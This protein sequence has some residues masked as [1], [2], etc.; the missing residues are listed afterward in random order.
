M[1]K[2]LIVFFSLTGTTARVA[3]AIAGGLR[4]GGQ[5]VDLC[6]IKDSQP[7]DPAGY[8]PLGIGVPAYYYRPPFNVTEYL[9]ALPELHGIRAFVFVLHGTHQGDTGNHVR[10]ALARKGAQ[11]IGYFTSFGKDLYLGYLKKGY[12]F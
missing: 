8:D 9:N 2:S 4:S 10:E 6:N 11:E 12:L 5:R 7:P 3:G 1:T